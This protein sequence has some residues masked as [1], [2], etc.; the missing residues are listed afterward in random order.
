M[1]K[2]FQICMFT[3]KFMMSVKSDRT[4]LVLVKIRFV[5]NKRTI[6]IENI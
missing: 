4:T 5:A 1:F 2:V 3:L 6:Y